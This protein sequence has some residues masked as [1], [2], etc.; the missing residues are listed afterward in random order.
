[1]RP[2]VK[3]RPS[4]AARKWVSATQAARIIGCNGRQV[5]LLAESGHLTTLRL[6]AINSRTRYLKTDCERLARA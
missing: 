3:G 5:A 6:P 4:N 1:M 2:P